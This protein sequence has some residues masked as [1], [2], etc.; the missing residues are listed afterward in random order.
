LYTPSYKLVLLDKVAFMRAEY[1]H[2]AIIFFSFV[3]LVLVISMIAIVLYNKN[4]QKI[5]HHIASQLEAWI[6]DIILDASIGADHVFPI[7]EDTRLLLN[8]KLARKVLLR[9]LVKV[10]KSL[11]GISGDNLEKIYTQLNLQEISLQRT[12]S[13]HW[14]VKA[15]GIQ[16]LATMNQ[17]KYLDTIYR[18]TNDQ[19]LMVRME[20]QTAMVRLKGY[21]GLDFFNA[22]TYP[23]SEWHQLNLLY[24]L[25]NQPITEQTGILNWLHSSNPTVVQF[26]L[27]LIAEQH[28]SE[29]YGDVL[30]CLQSPHAIVRKEAILCLAQIPSNETTAELTAHFNGED[31]KNLRLCIIKE[32]ERT[33]FGEDLSFLKSLQ[34]SADVDVQLAAN[35]TILYF[36]KH[37]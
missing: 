8:K 37:L 1:L 27:K 2:L 34:H 23:L 31:N 19:D 32:F 15:K 16:E 4:L 18:L 33:G 7:P 29:Y 3:T 28:A 5:R 13:K 6:M 22:L 12:T 11:S 10:K 25:A 14:H 9:E 21:K 26:S 36:Q 20:A 24:L 30:S 17:H 35:K